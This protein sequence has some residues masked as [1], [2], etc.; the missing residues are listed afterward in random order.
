MIFLDDLAEEHNTQDA[1]FLINEYGRSKL[2]Y[3]HLDLRS[4]TKRS[5]IIVQVNVHVKT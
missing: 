4:D 3:S 5:L 1:E 2:D